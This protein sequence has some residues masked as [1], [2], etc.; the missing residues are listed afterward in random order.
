MLKGGRRRRYVRSAPVAYPLQSYE[1]MFTT[2]RLQVM[3]LEKLCLEKDISITFVSLFAK[4][5]VILQPN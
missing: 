3:F 5:V 4:N 1:K 2:G